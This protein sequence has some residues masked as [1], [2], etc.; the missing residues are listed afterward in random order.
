MNISISSTRVKFIIAA[1][2][3]WCFSIFTDFR[4]YFAKEQIIK[5]E[6]VQLYQGTST[7][8]YSHMEFIAVYEDDN[9]RRFDR[10]VSPAFNSYAKVGQ[11]Y[12]LEIRPE[13]IYDE[14]RS[15]WNA[16]WSFGSAFLYVLTY[17]FAFACS[18]M[19]ILPTRTIEWLNEDTW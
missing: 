19:M 18:V 10:N 8:K 16:A 2:C 6:I 3:L 15:G 13:L 14:Y 4:P 5:A 11:R 17:V 7:G 12:D 1:I 9:G